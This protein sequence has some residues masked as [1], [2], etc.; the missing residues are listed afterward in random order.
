MDLCDEMGMLVLAGFY[1]DGRPLIQSRADEG[2]ADW[3]EAT[4]RDWVRV[5]RHHP[6]AVLWR[7]SDVLPPGAV[8]GRDQFTARLA[9]VVRSEDGTRPMADGSDIAAWSQ[10][11]LKDPSNP[12][13]YDDGSRVAEQLAKVDRPL[14]TKE[15]YTGFADFE[16]MSGFFRGFYAKSQAGGSTGTVVQHLPLRRA[17]PAELMWLSQ[18][19]EG[20]R[21]TGQAVSGQLTNWSDPSQPAWNA[22]QYSELFAELAGKAAPFT[23]D[24]APEVLVSGLKPDELAVLE[25]AQGAIGVRAAADGTAWMI[26]RQSGVYSLGKQKVTV[27][28][29]HMPRKP[30]YDY[31]QRVSVI[32]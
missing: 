26:V 20:N 32:K 8:G 18:S 2:W 19:G 7:P 21:D 15:L 10:N 27:K 17:V 4:C 14:L 24:V 6:S 28:P 22:S 1:C 11:H 29:G 3:M 12:N 5:L 16:K 9:K 30:G 13:E 23:G 31:V 25:G